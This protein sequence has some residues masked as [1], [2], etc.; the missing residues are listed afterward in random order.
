MR[1]RKVTGTK[2]EKPPE[3]QRVLNIMKIVLF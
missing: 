1:D 3:N 2:K